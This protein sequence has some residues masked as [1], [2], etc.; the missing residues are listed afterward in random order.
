MGKGRKGNK[1]NSHHHHSTSHKQ[2]LLQEYADDEDSEILKKMSEEDVDELVELLMEKHRLK[3]KY[4]QALS[5]KKQVEGQHLPTNKVNAKKTVD[6]DEINVSTS[7]KANDNNHRHGGDGGSNYYSLDGR[8]AIFPLLCILVT[9][10]GSFVG[11]Y[12]INDE[13]KQSI[14]ISYRKSAIYSLWTGWNYEYHQYRSS[15][16]HPV[17]S[18]NDLPQ[19]LTNTNNNHKTSSPTE[20]E[21]YESLEFQDDDT[22]LASRNSLND[23][24]GMEQNVKKKKIKY[25]VTRRHLKW[26]LWSFWDQILKKFSYYYHYRHNKESQ[27]Y[28]FSETS[29]YSG[30]ATKT[31]NLVTNPDILHHQPKLL[32]DALV[33]MIVREEGGFVHPDLGILQPA[34]SGSHRGIGCISSSYTTCQSNCGSS[35]KSTDEVYLKIPLEIQMTRNVALNVLT[36]LLP[37]DVRRHTPLEDLDDAIL[38][39]LLLAH[40]KC[41]GILSPYFP[42]IASLPQQPTCGY[43][44]HFPV[45]SNT[46]TQQSHNGDLYQQQPPKLLQNANVRKSK[47]TLFLL[48][49][50]LQYGRDFGVDANGWITDMEKAS[51]YAMVITKGLSSDYGHYLLPQQEDQ[52]EIISIISWALCNVASRAVAGNPTFGSLR[53]VPLLDLVNHDQYA[54]FVTE[55]QPSS[56][57]ADSSNTPPSNKNKNVETVFEEDE[58]SSGNEEENNDGNSDENDTIVL[59]EEDV[60]SDAGMMILKN[61]RHGKSRLLQRGE[62]LLYNYNMPHYSPFD[63]FLNLGFVPRERWKPW[64]KIDAALPRII[65]TTSTITPNQIPPN[66]KGHYYS[67][68]FR[69]NTREYL[70]V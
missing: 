4:E 23:N 63:W 7:T 56:S 39:T 11:M 21:I 40:E 60:E 50:I 31:N 3:K 15:Y 66:S 17:S 27:Y 53:L 59:E 70:D 22:I 18:P 65:D 32:W 42:Y 35:S 55:L 26:Y 25:Y 2:Q 36:P 8:M 30:G 34:P 47:K 49:S 68:T 48:R 9:V 38:L 12:G 1:H 29:S 20:D 57:E 67:H 41:K 43:I 14:G 6:N 33:E 51:E 64:T 58:N 69:T 16:D 28:Y 62:E 45:K 13:W 24:Q 52:E 19:H 46:D 54:A 10:I 61:S 37:T 5:F 44:H